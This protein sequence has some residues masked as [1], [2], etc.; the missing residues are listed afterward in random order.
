MNEPQTPTP[1]SDKIIECAEC[2]SD[3]TEGLRRLEKE[4]AAVTRERDELRNANQI[5]QS[6]EGEMI[7][8]FFYE[9]DVLKEQRDALAEAIRKHKRDVWPLTGE[10]ADNELWGTLATLQ[11]NIND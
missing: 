6:R 5:I 9:I 8:K 2:E 10:K 1:I 3:L 7:A 11:Q 4:L